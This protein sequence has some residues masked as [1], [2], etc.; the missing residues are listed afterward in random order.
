MKRSWTRFG[1]VLLC[2]MLLTG[3]MGVPMEAGAE[4]TQDKEIQTVYLGDS[5]EITLQPGEKRS[6]YFTPEKTADYIFCTEPCDMVKLALLRYQYVGHT[7]SRKTDRIKG[8]EFW[9]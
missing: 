7:R 1:V 8:M 4:E 9:R 2:L 5:W 6:F 3:L